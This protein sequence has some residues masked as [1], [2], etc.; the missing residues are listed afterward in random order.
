LRRILNCK[1]FNPS[2]SLPFPLV[3]RETEHGFTGF[4]NG[5]FI[6]H[7]Q[8]PHM[9]DN[10]LAV[11]LTC[12]VTRLFMNFLPLYTRAMFW[13]MRSLAT[14][15]GNTI[16]QCAHCCLPTLSVMT[17]TWSMQQVAIKS[18]GNYQ[19]RWCCS[20]AAFW[21]SPPSYPSKHGTWKTM[22]GYE[23]ASDV[24][25]AQQCFIFPKI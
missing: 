16:R 10:R 8:W 17:T 7:S 15:E 9:I 20:N 19:R 6:L 23:R 2:Q 11:G 3:L 25:T 24:N 22:L 4:N 12:Q 1:R 21:A 14:S 5:C 18:K 13:L